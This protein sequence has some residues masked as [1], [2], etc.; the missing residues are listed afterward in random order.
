MDKI[1]STILPYCLIFIL[2]ILSYFNF[3]FIQCFMIILKLFCILNIKINQLASLFKN[4][5]SHNKYCIN[6]K[7]NNH[8]FFFGT[9]YF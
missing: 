7:K 3:N 1:F 5:K 2:R 4:R 6:T 9:Y 8:Y